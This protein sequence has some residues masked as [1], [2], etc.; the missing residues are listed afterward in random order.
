MTGSIC[1]L[2]QAHPHPSEW[3]KWLCSN[4]GAAAIDVLRFLN[5]ALECLDP[6][7]RKLFKRGLVSRRG[8]QVDDMLM[9]LVAHQIFH[10]HHLNPSL[11]P[12]AC[13]GLTPDIALDIRGQRYLVDVFVTNSPSSTITQHGPGL[14]SAKDA[15]ERA[16]KIARDIEKKTDKYAR[17]ADPLVMVVFLGDHEILDTWCVQQAL[18]GVTTSEFTAAT[19]YPIDFD[20]RG[21]MGGCIWPAEGQPIPRSMLSAVI[22]CDWFDTLNRR[23]PGKRIHCTVLHHYAPKIPFPRMVLTPF[24]NV[25][26]K[27]I[28]SRSWRPIHDGQ[29]NMVARLN[30]NGR[31]DFGVYSSDNPW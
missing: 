24:H 5:H 12:S 2:I 28:N 15:G 31:F 4:H 8:T 10:Q 7:K 25:V 30:K 27:R 14:G 13:G 11:Y 16:R 17:C 1:N 21:R 26:W 23:K 18:Y 29:R 20:I 6:A 19:R 3:T 22:V 9:E